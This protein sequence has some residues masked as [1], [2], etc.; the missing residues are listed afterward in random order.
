MSRMLGLVRDLVF[1]RFFGAGLGMDVF[2]IAFQI[3]NF[4]RRMFGEGAFSQAFVPVFSEYRAS[5]SPRRCG[6]LPIGSPGRWV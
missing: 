5:K 4:L 2:V 1:A 3:P 6:S